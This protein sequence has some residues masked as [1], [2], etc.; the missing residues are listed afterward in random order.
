MDVFLIA[1]L[2]LAVAAI[3]GG[4]RLMVT[5]GYRRVPTAPIRRWA[6]DDNVTS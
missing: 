1:I 3:A 2:V 6:G 4:I 5:D